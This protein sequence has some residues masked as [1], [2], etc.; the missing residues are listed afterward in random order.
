MFI[1]L[2]E[3]DHPNHDGVFK[4]FKQNT[5]SPWFNRFL[6]RDSY[7]GNHRKS[8]SRNIEFNGITSYAGAAKENVLLYKKIN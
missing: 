1:Y 2:Y 3:I 4:T 8:N 5:F 7:Q 6:V